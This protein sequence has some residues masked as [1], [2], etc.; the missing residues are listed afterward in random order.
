MS[1]PRRSLPVRSRA[2]GNTSGG[3]AAGGTAVGD[4]VHPPLA[5]GD[6]HSHHVAHGH[7]R[8]PHR[9]ISDGGL[10]GGGG[11][12]GGE[13][14]AVGAMRGEEGGANVEQGEVCFLSLLFYELTD[15]MSQFLP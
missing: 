10:G 1:P 2:P 14:T 3:P 13:A 11:G 7:H 15:C 6:G 4:E 5:A 12:A 8:L 9:P